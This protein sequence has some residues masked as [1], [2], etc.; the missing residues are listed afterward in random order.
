MDKA[1]RITEG[2]YNKLLKIKKNK[3]IP[4]KYIIE[5]LLSEP[6]NKEKKNG[7]GIGNA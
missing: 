6:T 3:R 7:S 4:I 5:G 2:S 1:V